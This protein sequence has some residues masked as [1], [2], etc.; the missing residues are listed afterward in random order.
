MN[1]FYS[2]S[3]AGISALLLFTN[4]TK[5]LSI[6]DYNSSSPLL[7]K[8]SLIKKNDTMSVF[9]EQFYRWTDHFSEYG[10]TPASGI[11]SKNNLQNCPKYSRYEEKKES[12]RL[13][14][15][16]FEY[17][18]GC[19]DY[20]GFPKKGKIT[21]KRKISDPI[22]TG[23]YKIIIFEN[24]GYGNTIIN[25]TSEYKI[26]EIETEAN[27]QFRSVNRTKIIDMSFENEENSY[28]RKGAFNLLSFQKRKPI[29]ESKDY[30]IFAPASIKKEQYF[31][32]ENHLL[33]NGDESGKNGEKPYAVKIK[34][35]RFEIDCSQCTAVSGTKEETVAGKKTLFDYGTG[36]CDNL[37]KVTKNGKTTEKKAYGDFNCETWK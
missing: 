2:L 9:F 10:P 35:L 8:E 16:T 22:V 4:C 32:A 19:T 37:V 29:S 36:E 17:N 26:D 34:N 6:P 7:S 21:I 33:L 27:G 1:K 25:G 24:F 3:I 28:T 31:Y 11:F 23:D 15:I 13:I 5:E 18:F 20:W 30:S 14:T 12:Y